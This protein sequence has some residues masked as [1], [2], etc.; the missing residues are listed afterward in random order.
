MEQI[1]IAIVEDETPHA[2]LLKQH[3][4]SWRQ[5]NGIEEIF[6][7]HFCHA[8]AFLFA[9][10][11]EV[12]DMIF[13]D[14]QMP[15]ING[16]ETARK[17]RETD[18]RVKLVFTTGIADYL[19]EG[20]EVDATRYLLKPI[21]REKVWQCLDKLLQEPTPFQQLIFQTQ[22]GVVKLT[23]QE[24][25]YFEARGHYTICHTQEAGEELV[26]RESFNTL[27]DRLSQRP[28]IRCHR[29]YLC[30]IAHIYRVDKTQII[31][32]GGGSIPVSRRMY[33]PVVKAFVAYFR[34]MQD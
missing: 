32:E 28:F 14:I 7:Q 8:Q 18:N 19:Q 26:L 13:L 3:I 9:W 25:D 15:G 33:E 10:E 2:E 23:E 22:E 4:E 11:E 21:T 17:I 20:Y 27:C 24:I 16:M 34:R 12:Y 5:H 30:H 6:S 31:L 1:R 29:S